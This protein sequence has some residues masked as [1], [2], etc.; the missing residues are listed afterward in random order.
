MIVT[1][2][3]GVAIDLDKAVLLGVILS[4]L[5]FVPR[6]ARLKAK[7]LVVA[8][9]RVVRERVPGDPLTLPSSSMTWKVELF[10]G[11]APELDRHLTE[12]A[13]RIDADDERDSWCCGS[14]ACAIRTSFA[15]S[16]AITSCAS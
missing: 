10:F 12:L 7:E 13:Q 14:N 1:A 9:E 8:P 11:A 6:A 4:I 15:S 5:L 2:F 16:A 3:T